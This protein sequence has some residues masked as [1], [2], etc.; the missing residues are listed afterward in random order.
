MGIFNPEEAK[1]LIQDYFGEIPR[2]EE[3]QSLQTADHQLTEEKAIRKE[4]EVPED[5]VWIAWITPALYA[6]GDADLDIFSTLIADDNDSI[7]TKALVFDQRIAKSV[8]AYQSSS[9]LQSVYLMELTAAK[10]HTTDELIEAAD[11][12]LAKFK[13]DG[14]NAEDV[15][16]AKNN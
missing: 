15:E 2:G 6:D 14:A 4:K 16:I 1:A 12:V 9:R 13:E 7:L 5:K 10:G 11:A 3:V 8:V